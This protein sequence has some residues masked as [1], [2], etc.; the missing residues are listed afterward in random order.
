MRASSQSSNGSSTI[1]D[2]YILRRNLY[3][4]G[5][6]VG[7][8]QAQRRRPEF[9]PDGDKRGD[10]QRPAGLNVRGRIDGAPGS[11]NRPGRRGRNTRESR[12]APGAKTGERRDVDIEP[13]VEPAIQAR[14]TVQWRTQPGPRKSRPTGPD[15]RAVP[16]P[17]ARS[18][19]AL[20]EVKFVAADPQAV[21]PHS[22]FS[23]G[24]EK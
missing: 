17:P 19:R 5:N 18:R 8:L 10:E 4:S 24:A 23:G 12:S 2:G 21:Q 13:G 7:R 11:R 9:E 22:Q 14:M 15:G 20:E 1:T 6:S 3:P 16:R